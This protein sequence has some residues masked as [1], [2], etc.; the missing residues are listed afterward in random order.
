MEGRVR[1]LSEQNG[2]AHA[3]VMLVGEAPGR[4][5]AARTGVPFEGDESGRR[6]DRLLAAAGWRRSELFIT[7]AVLCNPLDESARNRPPRAFE[8]ANCNGWLAAQIDVIQPRLVVALG[9]VALGAL[10]LV[11]PHHRTVR[12]SANPPIAW[13]GRHL[14]AAYHPSARAAIHRPLDLQIQD[15]EGLGQWSRTR[16][17]G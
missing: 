14:A 15:F 9:A 12:D 6:L 16:Q 10:S 17:N 2:P 4:L 1:L 5:G 8:I 7:N 11:A 13:H 3:E